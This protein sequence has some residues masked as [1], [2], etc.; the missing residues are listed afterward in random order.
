MGVLRAQRTD[1][2]VTHVPD[3]EVGPH[4]RGELGDVDLRPLVDG[5]AAHEHLAPLVEAEPPAEG[6]ALGA[7]AQR[8]GLEREHAR[9]EDPDGCR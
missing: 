1:G 5:T 8:L 7:R 3:D 4:V 6:R 2:R 9:R